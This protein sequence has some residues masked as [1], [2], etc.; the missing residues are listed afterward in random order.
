MVS[1]DNKSKTNNQWEFTLEAG[2]HY[3]VAIGGASLAF[4]LPV[5]WKVSPE[6]SRGIAVDGVSSHVLSLRP[7]VELKLT[8]PFAVDWKAGV[9]TQEPACAGESIINFLSNEEPRSLP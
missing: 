7:A 3:S 8:R 6:N 5:N 9:H 1:H 4:A 2:P